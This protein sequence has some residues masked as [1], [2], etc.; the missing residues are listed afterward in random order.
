[1]HADFSP[2]NTDLY[3][4]TMAAAYF[5]QGME[6]RASFELFVPALPPNRN[7]LIAA[8]L[9]RALAYLESLQFQ[10]HEVEYLR[11]H[12]AFRNVS[13]EFF[14][15]LRKVRFE[16]DVW[17]LPEGTPVFAAEPLLRI[18]AP[19]IQ[20]QLVETTLLSIIGFETMVAS[21]AARVVDAAQGR[22]VVEFGGRH[23]HG[24]DAALFAA[25]AAYLAGCAGTSNALA[26]CRF[27]IPTTGTMAHSFIMAYADEGQSF[28]DFLEVFPDDAVLLLDTYDTLAGLERMIERGLRPRGVRLDSG[29]L[30]S[31]AGQVRRRLDQAGL[32]EVKLFA[33]GD[34]DEH[35]IQR[36]VA[37]GAPIDSFGVGTQ[38]VVSADQP[39]LPCVYKLVEIESGSGPKHR[40][41]L[42]QNK[43]TYPSCKQVYRF[44]N[45]DGSMDHDLLA[46]VEDAAPDAEPLLMPCMRKGRLLHP[47]QPLHRVRD[48]CAAMRASLPEHLRTLASQAAYPVEVTPMVQDMLETVR[49]WAGRVE[50]PELRVS[51]RRNG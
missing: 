19:I 35:K 33:T 26:G 20:A 49:A 4:L 22:G 39:V 38:L 51:G 8:G 25:R 30:A 13:N 12:R 21:K 27:G 31:L 24:P 3:E 18:T 17:A 11:G 32:S 50:A 45:E 7:Y 42:S 43:T 46:S 28:A 48:A 29:D 23:A 10:E 36:L 5:E 14:D 41:K 40:A 1:M 15:Y 34:L 16:G 44:H 47:A 2:L 6:A 9:E 37:A